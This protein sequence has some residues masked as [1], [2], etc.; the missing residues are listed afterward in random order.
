MKLPRNSH[1]AFALILPLALLTHIAGCDKPAGGPPQGAM[2]PA[3]V[4]VITVEKRDVPV[5]Y[6]HFYKSCLKPAIRL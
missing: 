3:Q 4:S 2:P 6:G 1:A 5:R